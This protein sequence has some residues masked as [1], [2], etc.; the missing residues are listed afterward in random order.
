MVLNLHKLL[1]R[2][3]WII[4][5]RS[6]SDK[7]LFEDGGTSK[8]FKL[9]KNTLRYWCAD[10][11]LITH[12][13]KDYVFFEMYDR[14]KQ[15]G[16]IGYREIYSDSSFSKLKVAFDIGCHLSYPY[17]FKK[18]NDIFVIPE[19]Y[20]A[21]EVS[22]YKAQNFP[23]KWIKQK[24]LIDNI[25]ACDT[26]FINNDYAITFV[27]N[28]ENTGSDAVLFNTKSENWIMT[29]NNPV[30][31]DPAHSRCA[32]KVFNYNGKLIRPAQYGVGGYGN[33]IVFREILSCTDDEYI[34]KTMYKITVDDISYNS[35]KKYDG[36]H[37]YNFNDK[38]E[39]IDLKIQNSLNLF[40]AFAT[41]FHKLR[42][43]ITKSER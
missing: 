24:L 41:V 43:I 26:T 36:I 35:S 8:K 21:N 14:F 39:V 32:G 4:A 18:D 38:Y 19:S 2:E 10:P 27:N 22:L 28:S 12:D 16:V 1:F 31:T 30:D 13:N 20:M 9:I 15:R 17:I 23:D 33:G 3:E 37:T 11:F 6:K 42:R 25:I 7:L 40:N 5:I 34:E 29:N